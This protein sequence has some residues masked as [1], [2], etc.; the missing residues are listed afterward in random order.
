MKLVRIAALGAVTALA[1]CHGDSGAAPPPAPA[2]ATP[3]VSIP[4]PKKGPSV[5]EQTLGMV[6]AASVGK[7]EL[8]VSLKF[9][10]KQ[11]PVLGQPLA[12]DIAVVPQIDANAANVEMTGIDGLTVLPGAKAF[13]AGPVEA[14]EVY[15]HSIEVTPAAEGLLLLGLTVSLKHDEM[16]DSRV[17]SIP[18][19]VER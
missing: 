17:F 5:S 19:I 8:P 2:P 9:D 7:S 18:L 4:A 13:A 1:A 16:T 11:R 15:R 14:G 3:Q 6:D 12:I 10:L